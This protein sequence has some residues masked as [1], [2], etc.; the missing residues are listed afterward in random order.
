MVIKKSAL[1]LSILL[2]QT[3]QAQTCK[4]DVIEKSNPEGTFIVNANGTVTDVVN[5]LLWQ[6]CL[7]GQTFNSQTELC[8]GDS[9]QFD[10]WQ[11][12]LS[13]PIPSYAGFN[14]WRLPNIKEL[15]IIV[16]RSCVAPAIDLSVFVSTPSVVFWSSTLDG[17]VNED[18]NGRLIDFNEGTEYLEDVNTHRFVRLV[19]TIK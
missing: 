6:V 1:L 10:T 9:K 2:A 4:P 7:V 12:A 19:R 16:E 14:G 13:E 18:K 8:E 17:K 5:A 3:A 11:A 15:S